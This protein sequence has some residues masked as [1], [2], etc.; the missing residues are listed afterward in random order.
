ML[1]PKMYNDSSM[2]SQCTMYFQCIL[3][4]RNIESHYRN[5]AVY[6][7]GVAEDE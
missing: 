1:H 3:I 6:D 7:N 5:I 4:H 2:H